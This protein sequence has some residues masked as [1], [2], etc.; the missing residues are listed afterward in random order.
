MLAKIHFH[1]QVVD[2][3]GRP[4]IQVE[5]KGETKTFFAEEVFDPSFLL[6]YFSRWKV[7]FSNLSATYLAYR[8]CSLFY[9]TDFFHGFDQNE[10][11]SRGVSGW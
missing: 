1:F 2:D 4:K 8:T 5:H 11:N 3:G 7:S 6:E 9:M 10:G